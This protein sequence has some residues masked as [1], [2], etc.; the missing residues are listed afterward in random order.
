VASF[1]CP[2]VSVPPNAVH[3]SG[4]DCGALDDGG[5]TTSID[6]LAEY[7]ACVDC[8]LEYKADCASA[9]ATGVNDA[10]GFPY[11]LECNQCSLDTGCAGPCLGSNVCGITIGGLDPN[12]PGFD[13]NDPFASLTATC[14][15]Q[16]PSAEP[17]GSTGPSEAGVPACNGTCPAGESCAFLGIFGECTCLPNGTPADCGFSE[18][19]TCGGDCPVGLFCAKTPVGFCSCFPV[20]PCADTAAPTCG[21]VCPF[22]FGTG[23]MG[24]CEEVSPGVCGC[25]IG[26]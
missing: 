21:G 8:V 5:D 4:L 25:V 16:V 26:P 10:A 11:P 20:P 14:A 15:C 6:T 9:A 1:A 12:E 22:D 2:Q 23:E 18:V 24:S 19:P 7:V 17:C 3:P 13:P